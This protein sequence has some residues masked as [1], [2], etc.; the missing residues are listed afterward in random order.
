MVWSSFLYF[1]FC[2]CIIYWGYRIK[3][4]GLL[5]QYWNGELPVSSNKWFTGTCAYASSKSINLNWYSE[6]LTHGVAALTIKY[7]CV[8]VIWRINKN[9]EWTSQGDLITTSKVNC[10][11]CGAV[12]LNDK[13][14]WA[15]HVNSFD[16][17]FSPENLFAYRSDLFA[18][19]NFYNKLFESVLNIGTI[20]V[21]LYWIVHHNTKL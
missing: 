12:C 3:I 18:G 20:D 8:L 6:N 19:G 7:R 14:H 17:G 21:Y 9:R 1:C 10:R 15:A 4:N 5:V 16:Q 11:M 2:I 13:T